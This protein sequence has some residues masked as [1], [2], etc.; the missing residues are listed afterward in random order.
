MQQ[1]SA[2]FEQKGALT[3]IIILIDAAPIARKQ[4]L[5]PDKHFVKAQSTAK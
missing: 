4:S 1:K 2:F 5:Q 3:A